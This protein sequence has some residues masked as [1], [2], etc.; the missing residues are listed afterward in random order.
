[1]FI[2]S[3]HLSA[4]KATKVDSSILEFSDKKYGIENLKLLIYPS[5]EK[6]VDTVSR[7]TISDK[8]KIYFKLKINKNLKSIIKDT[9]ASTCKFNKQSVLE[10]QLKRLANF[11]IVESDLDEIV[12]V[13]TIPILINK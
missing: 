13:L 6:I 2:I 11:Y 1:M 12:T 8:C 10:K 7:Q 3:F 9:V 5:I 4:Q